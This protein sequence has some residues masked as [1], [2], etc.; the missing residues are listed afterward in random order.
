MADWP[1]LA[2]I[3]PLKTDAGTGALE[4]MVLAEFCKD[5]FADHLSRLRTRLKAKC[6]TMTDA[7][8]EHFGTAAEITVPLG[9][10]FIWVTLPEDVDTKRLEIAALKEGISINPGAEWTVDGA[11]NRRRMRLCFGHPEETEICDGIMRLATICHR[12][13]GVPKRIANTDLSSG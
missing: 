9:G 6:D 13:F 1:V 2:Q 10:I 7:L 12:E 3:L 4:Q 11:E 8:E 5:H